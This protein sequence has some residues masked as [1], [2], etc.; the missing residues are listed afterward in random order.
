MPQSKEAL[1]G[2]IN[3]RSY[4]WL[5][6]NGSLYRSRHSCS[7]YNLMGPDWSFKTALVP[8]LNAVAL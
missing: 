4:R 3:C 8:G 2:E 6:R 5:Y 7:I 1:Y